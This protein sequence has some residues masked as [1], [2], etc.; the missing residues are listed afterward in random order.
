MAYITKTDLKKFLNIKEADTQYDDVLDSAVQAATEDIENRLQRSFEGTAQTGIRTTVNTLTRNG[1][2]LLW[3]NYDLISVSS[4][5]AGMFEDL[6]TADAFDTSTYRI[7]DAQQGL[8]EIDNP[9]MAG[10]FYRIEY[11]YGNLGDTPAPIN[12]AITLSAAL[13]M[14][15]TNILDFKQLNSV[16][17]GALNQ[18][19]ANSALTAFRKPEEHIDLLLQPY[20]A[21]HL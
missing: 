2:T 20:K 21:I 7:S 8:I 10:R 18:S 9:A 16:Q 1:K 12:E 13:T 4:I 11:T 6:A 5:R 17:L 14:T 3:A 19:L 15:H